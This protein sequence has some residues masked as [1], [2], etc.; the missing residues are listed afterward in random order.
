MDAGRKRERGEERE[1]SHKGE[2]DKRVR[3][4]EDGDEVGEGGG[5]GLKM[6]REEAA[7]R[8]NTSRRACWCEC[9]GSDRQAATRRASRVPPGTDV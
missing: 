6:R 3:E 8:E 1:K 4:G 9:V 5:G 2:E 7:E